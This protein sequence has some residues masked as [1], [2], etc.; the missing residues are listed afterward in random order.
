MAARQCQLRH[1]ETDIL[2][3]GGGAAGMF[4]AYSA[5]RNGARVLLIDKNVVGRGGA[6]R[7][8]PATPANPARPAA[9]D[10]LTML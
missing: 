7:W 10:S 8:N 1:L 4:A 6:A 9:S 3:A 2:V 5:A